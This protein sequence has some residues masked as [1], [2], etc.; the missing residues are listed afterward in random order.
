[1]NLEQCTFTE[2][3]EGMVRVGGT[4]FEPSENPTVKLEGAS[5]AGYRTISIAG[6]RD[7]VLID[8]I[9]DVLDKV[10][11]RVQS[12]FPDMEM[13][14]RLHLSIYGARGVMG[15]LEPEKTKGHELGLLIE[16]LGETQEQADTICSL[17]RSTLLHYGYDGRIATAGNLAFPF[18]PSDISAG[19]V[20][21]FSIYHL[22]ETAG[23]ELFPLICENINGGQNEIN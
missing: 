18:S 8:T 7:P 20:Y 9:D 23:K 15:S 2:L 13:K 6:T 10:R 14:N 1:M 16:A 4:L 12:F 19:A 5:L 11:E 17:F 3:E 22:M 21:R